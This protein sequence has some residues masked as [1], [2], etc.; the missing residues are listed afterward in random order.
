MDRSTPFYLVADSY[1]Q[2]SIGQHIP[3]QTRRLVYGR[4]GSVSRAEWSAAGELGIKPEIM[5]TMFGPDYEGEKVV[6][7]TINGTTKTF[8]VYRTYQGTNDELELYLEWKTGDSN[9]TNIEEAA[10]NGTENLGQ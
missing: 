4:I 3:V 1:T 10:A 9:G 7:M 6:Q 5:L 2:D 8:G